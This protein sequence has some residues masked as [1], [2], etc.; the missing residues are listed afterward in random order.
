M[1]ITVRTLAARLTQYDE[2]E[3][4]S[5]VRLVLADCFGLT[6][7]D[8]CCG[9]LDNL[10]A[11]DNERLDTLMERLAEGEPVQYVIGK[12]VFCGREFSVKPGCLIPRPETEE[13]C[14]WII[15]ETLRYED[16]DENET[17]RYEDETLRYEGEN[18]KIRILDIGTGSGCIAITLALDVKDAEVTAWDISPDALA[19]AKGNA[20]A[21]GADVD[22]EEQDALSIIYKRET[23]D[24][25]VSNPPYICNKESQDM[26]H[27]VLDHE[28][29]LA[30][31]VPDDDPLLFYRKIAEYAVHA[32]NPNGALYFEIN[33]IYVTELREMLLTLGFGKVE[34]RKDAYGKQRMMKAMFT[35]CSNQRRGCL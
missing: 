27:N 2:H 5:I 17:L 25:I 9:A 22:F 7:T 19:I 6:L 30:L 13:L 4:Q 31:F 29:H 21:L 14:Q 35:S 34:V 23:W 32:L 24:V 10:S 33:P 28:P 15:D 12:A 11:E 3:A 1:A 26:E 20:K 16:E 18:K 8:I